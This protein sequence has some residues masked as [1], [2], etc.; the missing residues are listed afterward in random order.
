MISD[1]TLKDLLTSDAFRDDLGY[2]R[3]LVDALFAVSEGIER[4]TTVMG[5]GSSETPGVLEHL[6][7]TLAKCGEAIAGGLHAIADAINAKD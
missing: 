2:P 7:M 5:F 6:D 3:N 1:S 4:Y